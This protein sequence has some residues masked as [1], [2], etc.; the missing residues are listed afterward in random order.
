LPIKLAT[1]RVILLMRAIGPAQCP[2][3]LI[4][5]RTGTSSLRILSAPRLPHRGDSPRSSIR[6]RGRGLL[7]G[8]GAT[9]FPAAVLSCR[10]RSRFMWSF[11]ANSNIEPPADK[12]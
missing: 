1:L 8:R 10:V 2:S 4:K 12:G 6:G 5:V 9:D 11:A 3:K 7:A